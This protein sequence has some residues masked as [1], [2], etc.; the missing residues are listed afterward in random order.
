MRSARL[1]GRHHH[2]L[3]AVAAIA[4]GRAA[5]TLCRGGALK[6]YHHTDPNEDAA[7]FALGDGGML[8]AVADGHQGAHGSELAI[9]WLL[10]H[11][12]E[13]WT[14]RRNAEVDPD[15]WCRAAHDLLAGAHAQLVAQ[16]QEIPQGPAPTTLSV[17]L[18]RPAQNLLLHASVGDSHVFV[19]SRGDGEPAR[20]VGWA[21]TGRSHTFF[22]GEDYEQGPPDGDRW[23]IGYQSLSDA[24]AVILASDGI[25]E[26]QIGLDD[27]AATVGECV[28]RASNL[29][30]ELRPLEAS[31][32]LTE[33]ALAAQR[34][35][36]AG[37]NVTAAVL[38]IR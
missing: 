15:G 10:E 21:S 31:R 17:V 3:G 20:D 9:R 2:E 35:H 14:A 33:A 26:R 8:G 7:C 5:I 13:S 11:H 23:R 19:A 24:E 30:L 32:W 22:L 27:P 37:D 1:L 28:A 34:A 16:G 25:S 4:E 12:A 29:E 36:E 6:T 38:W 18:V